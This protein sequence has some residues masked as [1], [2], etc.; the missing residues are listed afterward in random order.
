MRRYLVKENVKHFERLLQ[1]EADEG[2]R[3]LVDR[4]LSDARHELSRLEGIW[5]W[6]CPHV[7]VPAEVGKTF[8]NS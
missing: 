8:S 7:R 4:M 6:T 5:S 1:N 2:K 3:A